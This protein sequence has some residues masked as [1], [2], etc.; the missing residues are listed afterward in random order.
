MKIRSKLF[1]IVF[2][3]LVAPILIGGIS[4]SL[5]ARNAVT[6]IA[7]EALQ[8]KAEEVNR[9]AA[10]QWN[11]LEENGLSGD[12]AY[13][14]IAQ[15]SVKSYTSGLIRSPTELIA[16]I[17]DDGVLQ[18]A[19]SSVTISPEESS[20]ISTVIAQG[21][22]DWVQVNLGGKRRVGQLIGFEPF[23]WTFF[24]SEQEETFY[25]VVMDI[26]RRTGLILV[27]SLSLALLLIL[28][29]TRLL[30][31]PLDS[32][33]Q[34]ITE[35]ISSGDLSR[36]IPL[37]FRDEIGDLGHRFNIMTEELENAYGQ[38]KRYA[39]QAVVARKQERKIRN[40]FQKY[41]PLDVIEEIFS[42]PESLLKGDNRQLAVLFSDIRGF[43]TIAE[44]MPPERIVES[45]NSYFSLMV[46]TIMNRQGIV[47]KYIGDAIMAFFGAP[48]KHDNDPEASVLAA[49][50]MLRAL[51]KFNQSQKL[52][53]APQ[54][55]I[56]IGI[57]YGTVTIGNIGSEKKMDYTVIGDM[58]NLASRLEGLTKIYKQPLL[59]SG[60]IAKAVHH[61]IPCRLIDKVKVKGKQVYTAI[62]SP[63]LDLD[64]TEK[65]GWNLYH[66]ALKYYYNRNFSRAAKIL[67]ESRTCLP[68]DHMLNL[69]LE[70]CRTYMQ[71]AP[72][73]SW[74]GV[75][76]IS[77]K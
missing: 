27:I 29:F 43:T 26:Y 38:I 30:L 12:P 63:R 51:E 28:L 16:A 73:D 47:D 45:L 77:E 66:K 52:K 65:K 8:F 24:V 10:S 50:D 33:N 70:R 39:Y 42:N 25:Q 9:Y 40:I 5:S 1:L 11:L 56:G 57:N 18:F 14:E 21:N 13:I 71:E 15:T 67:L 76:T 75:V 58:V 20:E 72:A 35:I 62:Y 2:P 60:S 23:G 34:V 31:K 61:E 54:F 41:V 6:R 59:I 22:E 7:R 46:D 17:S 49:F 69:F 68:N 53:G 36:R 32:M 44:S 64:T 4:S 19:T 48:V 74:D 3:L 37:L 55:A